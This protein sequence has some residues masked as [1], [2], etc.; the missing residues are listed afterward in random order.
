M[1]ANAEIYNENYYSLGLGEDYN[2]KELWEEFFSN[3]AKRIVQDFNPKTVIDFGCAYGY[4][5]KALRDLGVDAWGIDISSYAISKADENVK[6][7]LRVHSVL[8]KLPNDLYEKFDMAICIEMIEHLYESDGLRALENIS[9]YSDT[10]LLS[11]TSRDFMEETHFNVQQNEYWAEKMSKLSFYK[12]LNYNIDYISLDAFVYKKDLNIKV[13][14]LVFKYEHKIRHEK[15]IVEREQLTNRRLVKDISLLRKQL[16]DDKSYYSNEIKRLNEEIISHIEENKKLSSNCFRQKEEFEYRIIEMKNR[17]I[18][19]NNMEIRVIELEKEVRGRYDLEKKLSN[20]SNN[21]KNIE[22]Q[23]I[24]LQREYDFLVENNNILKNEY[25]TL[26][27]KYDILDSKFH[28]V[29]KERNAFYQETLRLNEYIDL[30]QSSRGFKFLSKYYKIRD[31]ILPKNTYRRAIVKRIFKKRAK[32]VP[33]IEESILVSNLETQEDEIKS[34]YTNEELAR[35]NWCKENLIEQKYKF[36]IVVPLYNTP[37]KLFK[38]M[39]DSVINQI[40]SNW[41]LCIANSTP[42]NIAIKEIIDEYNDS[43]IKYT[44]LDANYGIS[45]NTVKSIELS[46]GDFVCF[47]DHDDIISPNAL[48]EYAYYLEKIDSNVDFFYSDKDM[49]NEDATVRMNPLFKPGYSPEMMLSANYFTHF[50]AI[51]SNLLNLSSE[52]SKEVDGAQDWD[53]YLKVISITDNIVNIP[54]CLYHWRIISTSVASGSSAKPYIFDAQLKALNSY[55]KLRGWAGKIKFDSRN[56]DFLR[57]H[58]FF[59]QNPTYKILL[60]S[61]SGNSYNYSKDTII[62]LEKTDVEG[63][64]NQ[65]SKLDVDVLIFV[66]A[67][68]VKSSLEYDTIDELVTWALHPEIAYVFPRIISND[69]L[70]SCGLFYDDEE[71]MDLFSDKDLSY[72]GQMGS[73][74]WYRNISFGRG[75]VFAI[76]TKKLREFGSYEYEYG[77]LSMTYAALFASEKKYRNIYNPFASVKADSITSIEEINNIFSKY[78]VNKIS[79]DDIYFNKNCKLDVRKNKKIN[80]NSNQN[81]KN[82][83]IISEYSKEALILTDLFDFN[84]DDIENNKKIIVNNNSNEVKTMLWFLPEFDYVFYAGLYTIFRT[85]QFLKDVYQIEPS[86]AFLTGLNSKEMMNRVCEGFPKFRECKSYSLTGYEDL[87]LIGRHDASVCTLWT[88]AY[89]SLKFNK[90]NKKFYFIQDYE[91]L[92][93]PAGSTYAQ[94]EVTYRFGFKGICNTFGLKNVYESNYGCEAVTLNPSIDTSI[95]YPNKKRVYKKDVYTLFFYGRPGHSRNGFEIGVKALKKLKE[96]M[97]DNL[98]IVTAGANYNI[99][100]FG[101]ESVVENLGRLK[102]EETGDLYRKCDIGLVMMFTKH[103]SYLPYELMACGC[104]V[105]SNYNDDTTWFLK[106]NENCLLALP[107]ATHIAETI[108]DAL[109]NEEIRKCISENSSNNIVNENPTWDDSLDKVA[110]F[111]IK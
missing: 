19:L 20:E 63:I 28:P 98:R 52:F 2:K 6:K 96:L 100:D 26:K 73:S 3:I 106:D 87:L 17:F 111:I 24:T 64:E 66:D 75:T 46:S 51:R 82:I 8:E 12:A 107:S 35:H 37:V 94:A 105:V 102:I 68:E 101:L 15:S 104:P 103:P 72:Y 48:Y 74:Y 49:I 23:L 10:I 71:V 88:T 36:S 4:L 54:L 86:F 40:Y 83:S 22:S 108:R 77:T 58:W 50:C 65:I 32:Q 11:S 5:V 89:Y 79:K 91:P 60:L 69:S 80:V 57:V 45:L 85:I 62:C 67:D 53:I 42:E 33:K 56:K 93:Y 38:E 97:R 25:A 59:K 76:E 1:E 90:V 47:L 99:S 43:R 16:E 30:Y 7:Y 34:F 109:E 81:Q 92:F 14:D 21:F 110:K 44:E 27:E 18:E 9:N 61:E 84:K 55:I 78:L 31:M 13:S 95:F 41:E 29:V 70:K 39:V